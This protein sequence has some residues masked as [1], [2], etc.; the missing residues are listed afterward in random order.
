MPVAAHHD[1]RL[2]VAR[3]EIDALAREYWRQ[4][5]RRIVALRGDRAQGQPTATSRAPTA[6]PTRPI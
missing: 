2:V 3:A 1:L 5:V 4:G 6:T